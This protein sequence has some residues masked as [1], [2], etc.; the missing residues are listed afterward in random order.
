VFFKPAPRPGWAGPV[1]V[2]HGAATGADVASGITL[3]ARLR[4]G[5]I[6]ENVATL[7]RDPLDELTSDGGLTIRDALG[8][9][10]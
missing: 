7:A 5:A 9:R 3:A 4:R 10:Q 8:E 1:V 6:I 2:C